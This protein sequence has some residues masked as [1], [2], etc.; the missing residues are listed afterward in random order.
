MGVKELWTVL[1]PVCEKIPLYELQNKT[2]AIDLS[3]WI[4][5]SQNVGN[6]AQHNIYLRNLF[7]R[8]SYLLLLGVKPIF[9][10]E[11]RAPRIKY[12]TIFQRLN[13]HG[14]SHIYQ[15]GNRSHLNILQKKCQTLLETLG[16]TCVKGSGEAEAFCAKL[17]E[18]KVVDGVISQDSDCFLYGARVV[19]RN[20]TMSPK[21]TCDKYTM[22]VI[23]ERLGLGIQKLVAFS[24]L[25]GCDYGNGV[26][27]V[28]K[29]SSL[30][31]LATVSENEVIDRAQ[32]LELNIRKK[33]LQDPNFPPEDV[34]SEFINHKD[35]IAPIFDWKQPNLESFLKFVDKNL[36]WDINY[37]SGKFN[38]LIT[39]WHLINQ[40]AEC[41]LKLM[42]I[43]KE[44]VIYGVDNYKVKWKNEENEEI[45]TSEPQFLVSDVYKSLHNDFVLIKQ[46]KKKGNKNIR[47]RSTSR[48]IPQVQTISHQ[49][50]MGKDIQLSK[51]NNEGLQKLDKFF[52]RNI[53][54]GNIKKTGTTRDQSIKTPVLLPPTQHLSESEHHLESPFRTKLH[55]LDLNSPISDS[56]N[57]ILD[58]SNIVNSIVK[59]SS[60]IILTE[61]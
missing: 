30:K 49:L 6:N 3:A 1:S 48:N 51:K 18:N 24:L 34:I 7:F 53:H 37:A 45:I 16:L 54:G 20:F 60:M 39:R 13:L 44:R 33:A 9:V 11:G 41:G 22:S 25:T 50:D 31:Y 27:G 59:K 35:K 5:D 43:E 17:N 10:L 26:Q 55:G 57:G 40:G 42:S 21:Y 36:G 38:P 23:E 61:K 19:F 29:E 56:N 58:L 52:I 32:V 15:N 4:V 8:T 47:K 28:G 12:N 14:H 2:I 46:N